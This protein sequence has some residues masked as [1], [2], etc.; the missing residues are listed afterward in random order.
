M[1]F[2][3]TFINTLK[4]KGPNA[5]GT[6]AKKQPRI[7]KIVG[8]EIVHFELEHWWFI[9]L[10]DLDHEL[11]WSKYVPTG[12]HPD[13]I[14]C[15]AGELTSSRTTASWLVGLA[16]YLRPAVSEEADLILRI[17]EKAWELKDSRTPARGA[18]AV[19]TQHL[20]LGELSKIYYRFRETPEYL[21][22]SLEAARLQIAMQAAAAA[23]W[24]EKQAHLHC[25]TGS[26]VP[27]VIPLPSHAGYTRMAIVLEQNGD[28]EEALAL[29]REAKAA[30]WNGDWDKRIERIKKKL[31]KQK[32]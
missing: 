23:A 27:H 21:E 11:I 16:G 13:K 18:S 10:S 4:S 15:A 1:G 3:F 30:G 20:A 8:G 28:F 24:K 17:A 22:R 14:G 31:K 25:A 7:P 12:S 26:R 2:F 9:E 32:P 29:V 6:P 19:F 5:N